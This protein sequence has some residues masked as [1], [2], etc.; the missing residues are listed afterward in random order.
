M[1]T[2]ARLLT[3]RAGRI[4]ALDTAATAMLRRSEQSLIGKSLVAILGVSDRSDFRMQLATLPEAG[5]IREWPLRFAAP[6][7][8]AIPVV[9]MVQMIDGTAP[10]GS[11]G[12]LRWSLTHEDGSAQAKGAASDDTIA[13]LLHDLN[14]PLSA[15][16]S[17]ARGCVLRSQKQ[18]LSDAELEQAMGQIVFEAARCA[19]M[20]RAA[21]SRHRKRD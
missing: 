3:T 20:L 12:N 21:A 6:D 1:G 14:Q 13:A 10:D 19:D 16:V 2:I 18:Q 17:Y 8:S 9:A 4:V 5:S 11:E 7:G 15:I